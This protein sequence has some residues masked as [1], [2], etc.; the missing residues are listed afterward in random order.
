MTNS[1]QKT[2]SS[3]LSTQHSPMP[4]EAKIFIAG[5]AGMV[6]SAIVR[7][8]L[9]KG[10]TNLL[11][12]YHSGI[13]DA[14]LFSDGHDN[15]EMPE[16]L[17]LVQVDLTDQAAVKRLFNEERPAH[18]FLAAA[19]VG[20][21]QANNTFPAQFI[22]ENLTIQGNIIHAAYEA[23]VSRLLFL[24][25]SCIYPK[26]APQPMNEE[27]LLTGLLE[28]TNEPYAIAKIAGIKMCESYNRQYGTR[29]MAVMPT[30][31]YGTN[32]NFDLNNSHVL[33]ALIRKFHL[34]KLAANGDWEK[35]KKDETR[36]GPIPR[37]IKNS[38]GLTRPSAPGPDLSSGTEATQHSVLSTQ[39]ASQTDTD[40]SSDLTP[41]SSVL[42]WGTG[43]PRR[44][45]LHVDDMADAC[46]H[47]MNLNDETASGE[48]LSYPKPCFVNIG[49]GTDCTIHELA[50][51]VRDVVGFPGEIVYDPSKPDGTPRKL[52]DV[53]R[54][55][56][57]G[58]QSNINLQDGIQNT[59][60]WY[61]KQ[62]LN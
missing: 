39:D 38:L 13:P 57:L 48:L 59:Y 31:L 12:S 28:P 14:G 32:D 9:A 10:Y 60:E 49:A 1:D 17:R 11:G 58:W 37:D 51:I 41:P 20:G 53:S 18:V 27:H 19:R 8:L 5:A 55:S 23:G 2:Q 21:I 56:R 35:I 16:G 3:A 42:I 45:F 36:F 44:E 7:R 25:S 22:H 43:T 6:G 29:F 54:L 4:V 46:V 33:P 24:G 62:L 52:L 15:Q 34:A 50:E 61:E 30:N 47:V 40:P 26:L